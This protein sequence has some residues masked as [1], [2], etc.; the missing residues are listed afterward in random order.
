MGALLLG[1]ISV[2]VVAGDLKW[3][4]PAVPDRTASH[5]RAVPEMDSYRHAVIRNSAVVAAVWAEDDEYVAKTQTS[6]DHSVVVRR[7]DGRSMAIEDRIAQRP[8]DPFEESAD[9]SQ[10]EL[11]I[12][13]P[14][15][16]EVER[17]IEQELESRESQQEMSAEDLFEEPP[18]ESKE[19][20]QEE[21]TELYGDEPSDADTEAVVEDPF[22]EPMTEELIAPREAEE[23]FEEAEEAI[24]QEIETRR[25]EE[26]RLEEPGVRSDPFEEESITELFDNEMRQEQADGESTLGQEIEPGLELDPEASVLEGPV[27]GLPAAQEADLR[28]ENVESQKNCEEEIA[29][30]R[31]DRI[32]DIDLS[33]QVEGNAGEDFP[34][35]CHLGAGRLQPRQWAEITYNWKAAG[36][37]H[38][39]LYFEQ[40]HLERYGHSWGPYVQP[41]MSG[42]HF[43]GTLPILPYKMGIRTPTECVYTLGYYR[44][45]SCAPYLID[46]VPFTW[47]AAM[48]EAGFATGAAFAIP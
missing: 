32:D 4:R 16:E 24:E 44:P 39:P 2:Q 31:A 26:N 33:L 40:V 30:V 19:A 38:K 13:D 48:F 36:L 10:L 43:F 6:E 20:E 37:C 17:A 8:Q 15:I 21:T 27:T 42:V 5:R 11:E 18:V 14:P 1:S 47:R 12:E 7:S 35:E 9:D 25:T 34:F 29:K 23:V 28:K 46:P 41:I 22:D 3:N 45:G